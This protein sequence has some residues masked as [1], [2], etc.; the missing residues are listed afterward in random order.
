MNHETLILTLKTAQEYMR[1][2]A[3]YLAAADYTEKGKEIAGAAAMID[4][5][6]EGI[7]EDESKP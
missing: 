1:L 5:W 6:I 2:A 3:A 4:D 7:R